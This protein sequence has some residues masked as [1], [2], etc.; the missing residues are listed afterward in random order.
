[1]RKGTSTQV[2]IY[3]GRFCCTLREV[4]IFGGS[5]VTSP[6]FPIQWHLCTVQRLFLLKGGSTGYNMALYI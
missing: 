2:Y 6:H 3:R 5:R 1:M 4:E